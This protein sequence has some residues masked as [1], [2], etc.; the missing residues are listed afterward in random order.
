M[1]IRKG[2]AE[3]AAGGIKSGQVAMEYLATYGWALMALFVVIALMI[4]SGVFNPERFAV[5]ECT[6]QP[7]L[8]CR[9][10][11]MFYDRP[12]SMLNV[13]FTITNSVGSA[14]LWRGASVTFTDGRPPLT[15]SGMP[16]RIFANQGEG[17]NVSFVFNVGPNYRAG[18]TRKARIS[19][20]YSVCEGYQS[21]SACDI[22]ADRH[23]TSGLLNAFVRSSG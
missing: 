12:A 8:P 11:F 17:T 2:R 20:N 5:E 19:L 4:A 13:S 16:S 23:T 3:E 9:D 18:T 7:N 1:G 10:F 6:L 14:V 22:G 15:A 21:Q